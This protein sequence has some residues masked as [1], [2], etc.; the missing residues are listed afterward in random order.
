MTPRSRVKAALNHEE[1][2]RVP[3]DLGQAAGDAITITAYRNLVRHLGYPDH[4]IR[5]RAKSTQ[6]AQVDEDI[7]QRFHVDFRSVE[8][9][10]PDGWTDVWVDENS[11]QDEW[12]V[13]RTMPPGAYY[14]DLTGSPLEADGTVSAIERYPWPDPENPGRYRGLRDRARY[15]H[16]ETDYAVVANLNCAFFLRCFEL[17]GWTN[18]YMDLA[19]NVDFAEK[20]MDRFLDIK[21]RMAEL[22]LEQIGEYIDVA[23]VSS[24]D[25]GMIDRP[26]ISPTMY[27]ALVKP[28]QKRTFDLFRKHTNAKLFYHCDGAIL[29]L[30]PD[31]IEIGV[32]ILNPIQLNAKD[33][34]DTAK[35]KRDFGSELTF[36]GAIDTRHVL[37]FGTPEDV[38]DEVRKRLG[39]LAPGG[40]YVVCSVHNIQP[41]VPPENV[42]A[43]FDSAYDMGRYPLQLR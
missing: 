2:D 13:V 11:Y 5:I 26:L 8:L 17:R 4:S 36:W 40:G 25:L 18:F 33:M 15:L 35:L 30:I 12:G 6:T 10:P 21:L 24:D 3:L 31:F 9:G 1:P 7:L 14:Y 29:P 19:A 37:P 38:R 20:L 23:M 28:R 42:E 39:D 16:E 22:A 32:D 43:K 41:E 34:G 27:R